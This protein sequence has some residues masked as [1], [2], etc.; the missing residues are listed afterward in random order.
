[1]ETAWSEAVVV[2]K[3]SKISEKR[4]E[5]SFKVFLDVRNKNSMLLKSMIATDTTVPVAVLA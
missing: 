3:S 4:K 1:M 5:R 2:F